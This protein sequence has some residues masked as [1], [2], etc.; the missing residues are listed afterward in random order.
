MPCII[1]AVLGDHTLQ[2]ITLAFRWPASVT[3]TPPAAAQPQEHG[4]PRSTLHPRDRDKM[5][6]GHHMKRSARGAWR[7]GK[8]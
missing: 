7:E 6:D 4:Y 8:T 3:A 2:K 5:S 1:R